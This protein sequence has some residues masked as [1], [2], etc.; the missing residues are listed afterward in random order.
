MVF[1]NT[2]PWGTNEFDREYVPNS[3]L[4]DDGFPRDVDGWLSEAEGKELRRLAAGKEV[5]EIGSFC[6]RSTICLAQTAL[7]VD[8]IDPFDGRATDQPGSTLEKFRANLRRYGVD[9]RVTAHQGTSDEV[10]PTLAPRFGLVFIDGDH[11][12]ESVRSDIAHARRRLKPG[13]LIAFHDYRLFRGEVGAAFDPGVTEAVNELLAAGGEL[14]HRVDSLA[15]VRPPAEV[16]QPVG[17]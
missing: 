11:S 4:P 5:L 17:E 1:G 13:G 9:L 10:A 2:K 12:L 15:V 7:L 14:L 16:L 6:G 3:V 8:C